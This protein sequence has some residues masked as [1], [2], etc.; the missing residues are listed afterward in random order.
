MCSLLC[1]SI[2]PFACT[3][4]KYIRC[5]LRRLSPVHHGAPSRSSF[6]TFSRLYSRVIFAMHT[7]FLTILALVCCVFGS[8]ILELQSCSSPVSLAGNPFSERALHPTK[9]YTSEVQEAAAA[10]IDPKAKALAL[11]VANTGTFLWLDTPLQLT[12]LENE[13]QDIPCSNVLGI[14]LRGLSQRFCA[15]IESPPYQVDDYKSKF[16]DRA[17]NTYFPAI[18]ACLIVNS[19]G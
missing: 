3:L 11:K 19:L 16:I 6:L 12:T 9:K 8:P 14:V 15:A 5:S 18:M 17:Y 10:I 1:F 4:V 2:Q 13:L 7:L